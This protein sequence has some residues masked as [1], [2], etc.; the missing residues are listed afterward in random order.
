MSR[1]PVPGETWT[2]KSE[3]RVGVYGMELTCLD[4]EPDGGGYRVYKNENDRYYVVTDQYMVQTFNPPT[5]PTPT[6]LDD[7]CWVH[8]NVGAANY[9]P[10]SV[11][12]GIFY[13]HLSPKR[14]GC[15]ARVRIL[16]ETFEWTN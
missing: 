11:Y 3:E 5:K 6:W 8:L 16:P 1:T 7:D 12:D 14:N 15:N 10:V 4:I 9:Y 13:G 2:R